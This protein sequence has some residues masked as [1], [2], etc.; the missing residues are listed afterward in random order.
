MKI[1]E[2]GHVYELDNLDGE[3]SNTITFLNRGVINSEIIHPGTTCQDVL[4]V[5]IDILEV[6]EDRVV[7]LNSQKFHQ[8]NQAIINHLAVVKHELR[9]ALLQFENRARELR[10]EKENYRPEK[11]ELNL[12]G[13]FKK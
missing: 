12:K 6:L 13:H 7:E 10:I 8:V 2:R 9:L 3:I 1:V 4:R 5:N 11:E